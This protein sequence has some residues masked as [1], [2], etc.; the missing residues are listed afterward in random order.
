LTPPP[1][2]L[3]RD[4]KRPRPSSQARHRR[5]HPPPLRLV[6]ER[7][8]WS[9]HLKTCPPALLEP[10]RAAPL[11][12]P[13]GSSPE[14]S[15]R[16]VPTGGATEHPRRQPYPPTKPS[17]QARV[18]PRPPPHPPPAGLRRSP[19]EIAAGP[20]AGRPQGPHCKTKDLCEVLPA[21]GNSNSKSALAVSCK[22]CRKS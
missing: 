19:A 13:A 9:Q 1:C 7:S 16:R 10:R 6:H 4:I 20:P 11:S 12:A 3:A 2:L 14:V 8:P 21:I 22:L 15:S 18:S 17:N 5:R